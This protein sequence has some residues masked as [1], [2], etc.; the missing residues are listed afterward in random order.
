MNV[1]ARS[2]YNRIHG[3]PVPEGG[4]PGEYIKEL[5]DAVLAENPELKDL[6]EAE[7]IP[8]LRDAAYKAQLADIKSTLADFGVSFDVFFSETTLHEGGVVADAVVR[9]RD[10]CHIFD[11]EGVVWLCINVFVDD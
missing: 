3:L 5:G 1:F 7:A 11:L 4:Y 10:W 9:L 6:E 2:V 8:A